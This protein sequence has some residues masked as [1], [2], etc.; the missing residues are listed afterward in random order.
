[1]YDDISGKFLDSYVYFEKCETKCLEELV[2]SLQHFCR[3]VHR[4]PNFAKLVAEVA[5]TSKMMGIVVDVFGV[6]D[7]IS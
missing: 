6:Y 5:T 7:N 1:M 2:F 4:V 3:N